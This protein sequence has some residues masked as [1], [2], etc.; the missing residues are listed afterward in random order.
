MEIDLAAGRWSARF[1]RADQ[2]V[3]ELRSIASPQPGLESVD[4]FG[5]TLDPA[6]AST[7]EVSGVR[8]RRA[9]R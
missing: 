1:S 9:A 3:A 6:V 5:W 2:V 7:L 4:W 8:L